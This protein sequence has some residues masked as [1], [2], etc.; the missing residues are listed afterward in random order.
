MPL[1]YERDD[2]RRRILIVARAP[3]TLEE[4]I[5]VINRQG[6]E[7]AWSYA[8]LYDARGSVNVPTAEDL[9]R[10]VQH[11]GTMTT[12]YGPRGRV[13]LVVLDPELLKM[14]HRYARLGDLTSL[15]VGL[16]LTVEDAQSW[17]AEPHL[18]GG[19]GLSPVC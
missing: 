14:G 15:A 19:F 4:T 16:F 6:A 12:K 8:M 2:T 18:P 1:H 9:H 11:V 10:L 13:A 5:A 3:V 17:L 7:G